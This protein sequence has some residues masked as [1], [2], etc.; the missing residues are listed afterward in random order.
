MEARRLGGTRWL[1]HPIEPDDPPGQPPVAAA[2]RR[3]DPLVDVM[4][5]V[6]CRA[7]L[8]AILE[9]TVWNDRALEDRWLR[10]S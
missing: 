6:H 5:R 9:G 1:D 7:L 3:H 8:A 2:K 4:L 10:I